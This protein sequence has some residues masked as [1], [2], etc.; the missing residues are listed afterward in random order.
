LGKT[1][2]LAMPPI[3]F[4]TLSWMAGAWYTYDKNRQLG[5]LLT[6]GMIPVRLIFFIAWI[7]LVSHVPGLNTTIL[8]VAMMVFWGLFTVPEIAM[9]VSFTNSLQRTSELEPSGLTEK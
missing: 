2:L 3:L 9:L 4:I 7:W 8:V 1:V 5:M 6:A